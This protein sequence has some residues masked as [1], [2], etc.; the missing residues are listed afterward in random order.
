MYADFKKEQK[1]KYELLET[2]KQRKNFH[3]IA[4]LKIEPLYENNKTT[5]WAYRIYRVT[6]S[7]K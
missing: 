5:P 3:W 1:E 6:P 4:N 2:E 7:K